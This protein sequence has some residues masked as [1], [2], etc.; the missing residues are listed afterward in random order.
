MG[1]IFLIANSLSNSYERY[2][3]SLEDPQSSHIVQRS[4]NKFVLSLFPFH[5]IILTYNRLWVS[6]NKMDPQT[7]NEMNENDNGIDVRDTVNS[8][9]E[10]QERT[11]LEHLIYKIEK[12]GSTVE[13]LQS[14]LKENIIPRTFQDTRY[15]FDLSEEEKKNWNEVTNATSRILIEIALNKSKRHLVEQEN[16]VKDKIQCNYNVNQNVTAKIRKTLL[17]KRIKKL[18]FLP[19]IATPG[20]LI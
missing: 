9:S 18:Q 17:E 20:Q 14:C 2:L 10:K 15:S 8:N 4:N 5:N 6:I 7:S 12:T 13:L 11:N 3:E 16:V 1:F 19:K